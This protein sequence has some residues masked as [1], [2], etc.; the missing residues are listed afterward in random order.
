MVSLIDNTHQNLPTGDNL[1]SP[2]AR[3]IFNG[4]KRGLFSLGTVL[5]VNQNI[6]G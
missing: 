3:Q 4:M 2:A 6:W 1:I 5:S